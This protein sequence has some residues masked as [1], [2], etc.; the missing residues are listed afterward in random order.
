MTTL[1]ANT[2]SVDSSDVDKKRE[3][4]MHIALILMAVFVVTRVTTS[5][6]IKQ[7]FNVNQNSNIFLFVFITELMHT[8]GNYLIMNYKQKGKIYVQNETENEDENESK[9]KKSNKSD[10]FKK[11]RMKL[12]LLSA[13][14][15]TISFLCIQISLKYLDITLITIISTMQIPSTILFQ[16]FM[17]KRDTSSANKLSTLIFM[18]LIILFVMTKMKN[19]SIDII[20]SPG[21]ITM[22]FYVFISGA[23]NV[24]SERAMTADRSLSELLYYNCLFSSIVSGILW[25]IMT[26]LFD[27]SYIPT[28]FNMW[29]LLSVLSLFILK[30]CAIYFIS[31]IDDIIMYASS[32][33]FIILFSAIFDF[34]I[35]NNQ[36]SFIQWSL[37]IVISITFFENVFVK[38]AS[39]QSYTLIYPMCIETGH[40]VIGM[41]KRG[42]YKGYMN[43][44][45]GKISYD[46]YDIF[47]S[48]YR[49]L[50]EETKLV[51]N[52]G[53][54][55]EGILIPPGAI[56]YVFSIRITKQELKAIVETEE[57]C[58]YAVKLNEINEIMTANPKIY[59][60][61]TLTSGQLFNSIIDKYNDP[62]YGMKTLVVPKN[63]IE[64]FPMSPKFL[65]LAYQKTAGLTSVVNLTPNKET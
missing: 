41:F 39:F 47:S 48:A 63:P 30:F 62:E 28:V 27:L 26:P 22:I 37:L 40:I 10:M 3:F 50:R 15:G 55:L 38:S 4:S 45:G 49:E 17:L 65:S 59:E 9:N 44:F 32:K 60:L 11:E 8:F 46:E 14:T 1:F 43:G 51:R 25:I 7:T 61:I 19:V 13:V 23:S 21:I 16:Y 56:N 34:L 6:V 58:P 20:V 52:A 64:S 42:Q 57:M 36:L 53:L 33:S 2:I 29:I 24:Y 5:I 31:S 35:F 12:Y 18:L 54:S